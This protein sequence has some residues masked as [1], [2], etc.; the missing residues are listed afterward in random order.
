MGLV[1]A[2]ATTAPIVV[3][4]RLLILGPIAPP[5]A[6]I[7]ARIT[8]VLGLIALISL[9]AMIDGTRLG[10]WGLHLNGRLTSE[11]VNEDAKPS[12]YQSAA[13]TISSGKAIDTTG[14]RTSGSATTNAHTTTRAAPREGGNETEAGDGQ[15][16]PRGR[17]QFREIESHKRI[18]VIGVL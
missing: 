10:I 13:P 7:I 17:A 11:Q 12:A 14:G 3:L 16:E 6:P 5:I 2:I 18:L 1:G 9:V 8:T 4:A 15:D